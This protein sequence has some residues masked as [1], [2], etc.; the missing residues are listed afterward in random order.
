[1]SCNVQARFDTE[2]LPLAA[3]LGRTPQPIRPTRVV[4]VM[5]ATSIT[6]PAKNVIEFAIRAAKRPANRFELSVIAFT[7]G[8]E[9]HNG[10]V[11][12][13]RAAGVIVD[14]IHERFAFDLQIIPQL[15]AIVEARQPDVIHTHAVK[16]HFL[17][18]LTRLHRRYP[19]IAFNRGYTRENLKV[20]GYNQLD[21]ICLPKA[22]Q[23]VTVCR[24]FARDLERVGVCREKIVVRH[25]MV[26]PFTPCPEEESDKVR[27]TWGIS[28]GALVLLSAGR[29][30]PEKGHSDLIE[31]VS[32]LRKM[33]LS[34]S[35]HLLI[36]GHGPEQNAIRRKIEHLGLR[37]LVTLAGQQRDMR[38]YYSVAD[39]VVLPSHSE[40]SPNVLL[41]AMAAG[42]PAIATNVGGI[43]EIATNEQTA[44][45]VEPRNPSAMAKALFRFLEGELL[46]QR[47]GKSAAA[48]VLRYDPELYCD[49][50]VE[51]HRRMLQARS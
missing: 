6:G 40:G 35:F 19:W 41:E 30:S 23:V 10:F 37:D 18:W 22:D 31:A 28:P 47:L 32:E 20:R 25:N 21:R 5:E 45:L 42:I 29:L 44:L 39:G 26:L 27:Q 14:V 43:P 15:C 34:R 8:N 36:V 38:P 17:V 46:R 3:H 51:I 33:R 9:H 24:A 50:M 2:G 4:A 16:S 7:R 49:A 11:S 13:A 48:A 1:M 12:A